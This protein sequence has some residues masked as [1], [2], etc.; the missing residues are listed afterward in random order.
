MLHTISLAILRVENRPNSL[1]RVVG[2]YRR[3]GSRRLRLLRRE[4]GCRFA[5]LRCPRREHQTQQHQDRK[6]QADEPASSS[7][8]SFP[9]SYYCFLNFILQ[10]LP[11]SL[12]HGPCEEQIGRADARGNAEKRLNTIAE[13]G[14]PA[15]EH[16]RLIRPPHE[17]HRRRAECPQ[18]AEQREH[19]LIG[20]D[21]EVFVVR[22]V[23]RRAQDAVRVR[24][25]PLEIRADLMRERIRPAAE[26]RRA[27]IA[28]QTFF[29]M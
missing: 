21:V 26:P 27:Q 2:L 13:D 28:S 22:R 6:I 1:R 8:S 24:V 19:A 15:D 25:I 3:L 29:Q 16:L 23:N 7:H 5:Q 20:P 18:P 17:P 4:H 12:Q 9:S 14:A 11:L 10:R